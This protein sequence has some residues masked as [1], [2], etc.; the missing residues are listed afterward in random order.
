MSKCQVRRSNNI[1]RNIL[2]IKNNIWYACRSGEPLECESKSSSSPISDIISI[3][4]PMIVTL[5][6]D[7]S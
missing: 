6:C 5:P 7:R 2:K 3:N 4:E 1:Q